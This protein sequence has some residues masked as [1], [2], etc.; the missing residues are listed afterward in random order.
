M[1]VSIHP[2]GDCSVA[3]ARGALDEGR[4][5]QG[6][7]DAHWRRLLAALDGDEA[8]DDPGPLAALDLLSQSV[9][10]PLLDEAIAGNDQ[11]ALDPAGP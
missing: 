7:F 11:A 10:A 5:L 6:D 4:P 8:G 3:N 2:A 1:S 9:L